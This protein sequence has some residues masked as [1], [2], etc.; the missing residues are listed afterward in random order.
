MRALDKVVNNF[1]YYFYIGWV[2]ERSN[3]TVCKTVGLLPFV[4]SNPTP[5]NIFFKQNPE[6]D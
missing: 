6:V 1:I 5:T 2:A 3:A 4:G